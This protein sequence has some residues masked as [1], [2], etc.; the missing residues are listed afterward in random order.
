MLWGNISAGFKHVVFGLSGWTRIAEI[1]V[2]CRAASRLARAELSDE[3]ARARLGTQV[4]GHAGGIPGALKTFGQNRDEFESDRAFRLL[5]AISKEVPVPSIRP[6]MIS[7]FARE[8]EMGRMPLY[9][10]VMSL[11]RLEPR[12]D[13]LIPVQDT[14]EIA[15]E[16]SSPGVIACLLGPNANHSDAIVRSQLA[17]SIVS[18]YIAILSGEIQGDRN[19]AYFSASTRVVALSGGL[20]N[21]D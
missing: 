2:V 18:Q 9:E 12:L 15:L 20:A 10:A 21:R 16:C 7:K 14:K 6:E 5:S 13:A 3:E 17:L 1:G 19:M 11:V 8:E 4:R